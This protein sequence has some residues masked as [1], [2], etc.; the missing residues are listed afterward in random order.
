MSEYVIW[1]DDLGMNDVDRVGGK[2]ASLGEMI[3]QLSQLGVSVPGGFATT[4][5]A[6]RDFLQQSGLNDRIIAELDGF[7]ID[8]VKNLALV[9]K[10]IRQWIV[11]T[12]FPEALN[13]AVVEAYAKLVDGNESMSFAVRSSATAEDLPD[14]SFAGQQETFLNIRG[15]DNIMIAIK[16]VF[17]W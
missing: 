9:G 3:S 1:F 17:A 4:A 13:A 6:F 5:D 11:E 10:K 16:E 14:A 7:D 8:D 2:N 12:P 15:L